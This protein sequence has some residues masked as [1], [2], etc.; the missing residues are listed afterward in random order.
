MPYDPHNPLAVALP[1]TFNSEGEFPTEVMANRFQAWRSIIKDLVNYLKEYANV[2]EERVR[3]QIRLQQAVGISTSSSVSANSSSSHGHSSSSS[4]SAKDDLLAINKFFLPIGN[5][6]VQDLP[7]ILT[8]FH[9]QNVTNSSKTLKDI[10]QIIIPK[11]EELRKDLLVKIKE[12]K[13][14]QNDFK[15]SLG[16]ELSETKL[17]ISQYH[18]AFELSNKLEHGSSSAHHSDSGSESGK[19][20]PY[21]VKIKLDRQLKRQLSEENYLYEAYTNL[22][23][24]GGK[25]E[26]IIVLE[27]QNYLSMFL[28]LLSTEN[29]SLSN[30]LLPN[31]NNGFLSKETSFEWDAFI[32]RNLPAASAISA[33]GINSSIAKHGTFIDLSIPQRKLSELKIPNFDSNLNVAIRE[34]FLERRSKY[35]KSYS[36]GWYVLTCNYIHEFK[37]ADRKKDQQP[38]M[39]L[40]LDTCTVSDHSKDDGKAGGAYKFI[41]SSKSTSGLVHRTHNLV[42]RTDTFKSMIDWYNDIKMLTSLPTPSARGRHIAKTRPKTNLTSNSSKAI[43]R[44]SSL[45]SSTTNGGRSIRT[46]NS[47]ASPPN[48]ATKQRPLSQATSIM[49]ANRLSST[50]SQKNSQSPRMANMINSDGTIITPVDTFDSKQGDTTISYQDTPLQPNTSIPQIQLPQ[51]QITP[52]PGSVQN[53][54]HFIT[55]TSGFQ[56]YIPSNGQPQQFYDPVQ[57][58]YYTLTPSVPSG[59]HQPQPQPQYFPN[60][61]Q[62]STP[63]QF[64]PLQAAQSPSQPY[65]INTANYFP[66]YAHSQQLQKGYGEN[67]PYPNSHPV[68]SPSETQSQHT[69]EEPLANGTR[70][71]SHLSHQSLQHITSGNDV[72]DE[73]STLQSNIAD[74]PSISIDIDDKFDE[75]NETNEDEFEGEKTKVSLTALDVQKNKV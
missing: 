70:N 28:N 64:V 37:T 71:D 10:N 1:Y 39:S 44:A 20:D 6:S 32:S 25:L 49:N 67:L 54:Q 13:N 61:P 58:Q 68:D 30:F 23:S 51:Q 55:P 40:S 11:L 52:G 27:V 19:Y 59:S 33:V 48:A 2:Q 69:V 66:Q 9:Q 38:V 15:T 63:Q 34:G 14:L 36:S 21:L 53:Q 26:S 47:A 45:Y 5:G 65:P 43:S 17:L 31:L 8:K 12:I 41:L 46:G 74:Q 62:Q 24:S 42:F 22:Q 16:K 56:Y 57:N 3:Q 18:Q 72:N 29:S 35:L 73:V 75:K 7:T 4:N 60:T 50:F